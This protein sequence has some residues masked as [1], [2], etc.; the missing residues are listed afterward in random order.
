MKWYGMSNKTISTEPRN[1]CPRKRDFTDSIFYIH[2]QEVNSKE[3]KANGFPVKG[4]WFPGGPVV[5]T[6]LPM[7]RTWVPSL[8]GELR[9]HMLHGLTE[10]NKK[11][12]ILFSGCCLRMSQEHYTSSH[13]DSFDF[14][15]FSVGI[16]ADVGNWWLDNLALWVVCLP[17]ASLER[18]VHINVQER[19]YNW[20]Y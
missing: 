3:D 17:N 20:S 6:V 7:Q 11:N 4:S 8:V 9:S 19:K 18:T 2:C 15:P 12:N 14:V 16:R 1:K 5:K 10:K 13:M